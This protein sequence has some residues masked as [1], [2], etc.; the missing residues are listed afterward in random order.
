L[1]FLSGAPWLIAI[2]GLMVHCAGAAGLPNSELAV[3]DATESSHS[4]QSSARP[5]L[6]AE[7]ARD[8]V[9][10][11]E[12]ALTS[13]RLRHRKQELRWMFT[14]IALAGVVVALLTWMLINNWRHRQELLRLAHQD[15]LTGL[16]NR[17]RT[18]EQAAAAL[19]S[20]AP[21]KRP[22]TMALL[23]LDHFKSIN[24]RCGHAVGDR[25]LQDFARLAREAL[26]ATD[27]LGRWGGEEFLLILPDTELDAALAIVRRIRTA[28]SGIQLPDSTHGL[29]VTFSA[30]LATRSAHI[31]PLD[32]VIACADAALYEAKN[33]GRNSVRLDRETYQA[34]AASV[35]QALY[36]GT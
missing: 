23:D 18:S 5:D 4:A 9:L 1:N 15:V 22:V 36:D 12:L 20:A 7:I 31:Q 13:E 19:T 24:D 14:I 6:Q 2:C 11:H 33:G 3:L 30:G 25:V 32:E 35:R 10:Q 17:R 21:L 34:A 26:R 16:P 29:R 28:I 8:A 27:T